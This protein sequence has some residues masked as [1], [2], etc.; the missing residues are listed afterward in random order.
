MRYM[1]SKGR[2]AKYILPVILKDRKP[3]QW[4]VEPFCGGCNITDKVTGPRIAADAMPE[5][6][7][8]FK[9]MQNGWLQPKYIKE[10][11]WLM[12]RDKSNDLALR[13][14]VGFG[15]S[16]GGGFFN[17]I[18]R[19]ERVKGGYYSIS[20]M[21]AQVY[22][23]F[24]VQVPLLQEVN[25]FLS[26]YKTLRIPGDS[27]IYCDP[28]YAGTQNYKT[29]PFNGNEFYDW[30][31]LQKA[32]G[33]QIFISEYRMPKDFKCVFEK[34]HKVRLNAINGV[35]DRTEKLFTL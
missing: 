13:G 7:A 9:A 4:F 14:Y 5:I 24:I 30:C 2:I 28:P 1:G 32:K 31:R 29:D 33:R 22:A 27:I 20:K 6:I 26:D 8:M 12:V 18:A 17:S 11:D 23:S 19:H 15:F 35:K 16:F 21:N 10:E 3:N 34:S 25:F